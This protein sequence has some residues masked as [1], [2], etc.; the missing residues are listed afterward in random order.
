MR[1]LA[2][3]SLA[4]A[5]AFSAATASAEWRVYIESKAV[6]AGETGVTLDFT[7]F[8]DVDLN[9]ITLPVVVREINPG[10]FWA[11][12]LPVDTGGAAPRGVTWSWSNPGWATL[13]E[14]VSPAAG[15]ATPGNQYDGVSPDNFAISAQTVFS[16]SP[17]EPDGRVCLTLEFDVTGETG[18]F[19]FDTACAT[20][21]LNTIYTID[22]LDYIDHG[23][24]GTGEASFNKGVIRIIRD[25]DDDGIPDSEDNCPQTANPGQ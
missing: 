3:I 16:S 13:V 22:A 11:G 17:P 1:R 25:S 8:W 15:C 24:S 14:M 12:E 5:V 20:L 6:W 19:E 2:R 4:V 7:F 18:E 9:T 10:S 21:S 23:P